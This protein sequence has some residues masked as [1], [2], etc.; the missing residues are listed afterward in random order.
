MAEL[1]SRAKLDNVSQVVITPDT[2]NQVLHGL[3]ADTVHLIELH[4]DTSVEFKTHVAYYENMSHVKQL[5]E[6]IK[7]HNI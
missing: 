5:I 4:P 1:E 7:V 2:Y 3:R 6:N